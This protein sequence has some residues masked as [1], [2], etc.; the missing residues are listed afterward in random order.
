MKDPPSG[1]PATASETSHRIYLPLLG[2]TLIIA[3]SGL[4]Y[5]LI[6]GT[7]SSYL[8]GDSV[9]QFSLVIGL[10]MTAMG[11]GAY[12]SRF[13]ERLEVV[14]VGTQIALGL[15]GGF[16]APLLFFAFVLI[17]NYQAFLFVIC[18][19]VGALVGLE[20]P[21]IVRI[22]QRHKALAINISNILTADYLGALA[23]AL[24][25]PLVLVPQ[26]G[27]MA[28]SLVFGLLNLAV[29]GLAVW[30]FRRVTGLAMRLVLCAAVLATGVAL[31]L[32]DSL[33]G[34]LESR[35]YDSEI[36]FAQDTAYQ[37][38]V[39]TSN[40]D[41][42]QLFLNGSLQFD[43]IDEY[44][45]HEA[46]VHPAMVLAPRHD[47][48]LILGGGDGMA[49]REVLR[50]PD[51]AAITLVDLDP[52]MTDLFR[53]R[54]DL[55]AL[56]GHALNDE[57]VAIVNQDAWAFVRE[58]DDL[59]DVVII[60]LPDPHTLAV[61]KLYSL[62]FYSDLSRRMP[63]DGILVT[64]ASS[65]LYAREAYWSIHNTLAATPS[66]YADPSAGE[67]LVTRPYHAYVPSFGDWGFIIAGTRLP[68]TAT[69][70]LPPDLRFLTE[71]TLPALV[72]FPPD[73]GQVPAD[74]NTIIDHPLIEYYADGW[75]RWFE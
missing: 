2:A 46:L 6:A 70:P 64:Q 74:I 10:F 75:R 30:L 68:H 56:N 18:V 13:V 8:L 9:Y 54:S 12:L 44:R 35:F 27:L 29:A 23:A 15:I 36:L 47:H 26:L 60:D 43:T 5:E 16:S 32:S 73:M 4:V 3:V 20:I 39:L 21:L 62:G 22:L 51:V 71:A 72:A 48:V 65:P 24:L 41:H 45:Y 33:V 38:L 66:P 61:S 69:R 17:D 19:I 42:T 55:A 34:L 40:G 49:A 28:A 58:T 11:L 57:R 63:V 52:V 67:T 53:D 31:I 14:F 1:Q 37:R 7:V 59:F 50:Y 25:F